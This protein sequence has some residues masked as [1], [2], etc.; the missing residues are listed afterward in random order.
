M[1]L[2]PVSTID[3]TNEFDKNYLISLRQDLDGIHSFCDKGTAEILGFVWDKES[4]DCGHGAQQQIYGR[5]SV[6]A[7]LKTP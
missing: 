6:Y 3:G 2:H 7:D 1:G 5:L 4:R